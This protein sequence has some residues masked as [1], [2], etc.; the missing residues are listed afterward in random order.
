MINKLIKKE[1]GGNPN[2]VSKVGAKGYAQI[3]PKTRANPGFGVIA[4]KDDSLEEHK[5]FASEYVQ[6]MFNKFGKL[7]YALAAYNWG[8][9]NVQK[10]I[11]QGAD[12]SKL[13]S[14]TQDYIKSLI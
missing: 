5:R 2:A 11:S 10:W 9:G 7:E 6:A 3:M 8:P 4:P 13:P 12:F 14:E 1:S